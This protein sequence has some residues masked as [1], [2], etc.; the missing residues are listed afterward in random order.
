[1][2]M[3]SDDGNFHIFTPYCLYTHHQP[4]S[5]KAKQHLRID[6]QQLTSSNTYDVEN[7]PQMEISRDGD[8]C[9]GNWQEVG[10]VWL[11]EPTTGL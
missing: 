3:T 2:T 10:K 9:D 6:R 1:M 8:W 4:A 11:P 7:Q 5:Q